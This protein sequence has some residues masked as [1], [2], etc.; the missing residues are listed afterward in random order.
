MNTEASYFL[1]S[2]DTG[3]NVDKSSP[4]SFDALAWTTTQHPI[5]G[6]TTGNNESNPTI[7]PV[8]FTVDPLTV[9]EVTTEPE[10]SSRPDCLT[11]CS[12]CDTD[13]AFRVVTSVDLHYTRNQPLG[14]KIVTVPQDDRDDL[15]YIFVCPRYTRRCSLEFSDDSS[16]DEHRIVKRP[17]TANRGDSF[18]D[19]R[20]PNVAEKIGV[21]HRSSPNETIQ[22]KT[23]LDT[24][25]TAFH[26]KAG[27]PAT[28]LI[29]AVTR[30]DDTASSTA[31]TL[32]LIPMLSSSRRPLVES[33]TVVPTRTT[34]HPVAEHVFS[35]VS[36]TT[37]RT[38]ARW[39]PSRDISRD[40]KRYRFR[41]SDYLCSVHRDFK[42]CTNSLSFVCVIW[43]RPPGWIRDAPPDRVL[44]VH[45]LS[46]EEKKLLRKN[47]DI[48]ISLINFSWYTVGRMIL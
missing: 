19:P 45:H 37:P 44:Y 39:I 42:I 14:S 8:L 22:G 17:P 4:R 30:D 15:D 40:P 12:L 48:P 32:I 7:D 10:R 2:F 24:A 35:S 27:P 20:T 31:A 6:V 29:D 13:L 43:T 36:S 33:S 16:A 28:Q 34:T 18:H 1:I 26:T 23:V 11:N 9:R 46:T 3:C 47:F 38:V 41:E 25:V 21:T 5:P